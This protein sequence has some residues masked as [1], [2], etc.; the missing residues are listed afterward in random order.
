MGQ[1]PYG[2]IDQK[3]N[4]AYHKMETIYD[5]LDAL[6]QLPNTNVD[7]AIKAPVKI[8]TDNPATVLAGIQT[9]QSVLL[10]EG[11]R[12]YVDNST[13]SG[14]I[15]IV[16]SGSWTRADDW[17]DGNGYITKGTKF[18]IIAGDYINFYA[19]VLNDG[20]INIGSTV[21]NLKLKNY[22]LFHNIV[23]LGGDPLGE[24][25]DSTPFYK[26]GLLG[27]NVL[28]PEGTFNISGTTDLNG[29]KLLGDG[30]L[31]SVI[32]NAET[33]STYDYGLHLA[34]NSK[35]ENLTINSVSYGNSSISGRSNCAILLGAKLSSSDEICNFSE[36]KNLRVL[37]NNIGGNAGNSV[38]GF[39]NV[40]DILIENIYIVTDAA[41]GL[42]FHWGFNE[43]GNRTNHPRRLTL[44]NLHIISSNFDTNLLYF[45]GCHDISVQNSLLKDGNIGIVV[46]AGDVGGARDPQNESV[47]LICGNLNFKGMT[48]E[49][50][51]NDAFLIQGA[52]YVLGSIAYPTNPNKRWF[53]SESQNVGV[54]IDNCRVIREANSVNNIGI[55]IEHFRNIRATNFSVGRKSGF[56]DV[57]A[58]EALTLKA[59]NDCYVQMTSDCVVAL[60]ALSGKNNHFDINHT[61]SDIDNTLSQNGVTIRA[62][63]VEAEIVDAVDIN[64]DEIKIA[65]LTCDIHPGMLFEYN[66]NM[67]EFEGAARYSDSEPSHNENVLVAIKPATSSIPSGA[68]IEQYYCP[69]DLKITG[70]IKGMNKGIRIISTDARVP[71]NITIDTD[72]EKS[73]VSDIEVPLGIEIK[74][75][76]SYYFN[77]TGGTMTITNGIASQNTVI[78]YK[79]VG[80]NKIGFGIQ[81]PTIKKWSVGD[82][83][84]NTAN[85]DIK[86][87]RCIDSTGSGTWIE[88]FKSLRLEDFGDIENDASDAMVAAANSGKRVIID[89][90]DSRVYNLQG[91]FQL[92]SGTELV[93]QNNPTINIH[94]DGDLDNRNFYYYPHDDEDELINANISGNATIHITA[95]NAQND[96]STLTL[97]N[98]GRYVYGD[99]VD[100]KKV[101]HCHVKGNDFIIN[102]S[103]SSGAVPKIAFGWGWVEDCS[104]EGIETN[105]DIAFD[106]G[107]HWGQ[108]ITQEQ[109]DDAVLPSKTWHADNILFRNIK[110]GTGWAN[111]NSF[112][113][114]AAGRI[115]LENCLSVNA[116]E[117][118]NL[119]CGDLGY[120]YCENLTEKYLQLTLKNFKA[121][122]VKNYGISVDQ[123]TNPVGLF[124][125]SQL[126]TSADKGNGG[127]LFIDGLTIH[128][129]ENDPNIAG[130]AITGL[131]RVVAKNINVISNNITNNSYA[132]QL[133]GVNYAQF[134]GRTE[135][136][137]GILTRNCG[138][139]DLSKLEVIRTEEEPDSLNV[140]V[141]IATSEQ[142]GVLTV[143]A[144]ALGDEE[145]T[146]NGCTLVCGAGGYIKVT[147]SATEYEIPLLSSTYPTL[148]Q[149]TSS[150][151]GLNEQTIKIPPCPVAIPNGTSIILG[152]TVRDLR[153]RDTLIDKFSY[154]IRQS[155]TDAS[156]AKR[157]YCS[158]LAIYNAGVYGMDI[159]ACEDLK[160]ISGLHD[161]GG[162]RTT[163]DNKV[164]I[165]L[166]AGVESYFIDGVRFGKNC[167]KLRYLIETDPLSK[168]VIDNCDF[169][170]LNTSVSNAACIFREGTNTRIG[171]GNQY[172]VG[173]PQIYSTI[174]M[175]F[176]PVF[177]GSTIAGSPTGSFTAFYKL[178]NGIC[179]ITVRASFTNLGGMA[180]N[181]R[182]SGLPFNVFNNTNCR[183]GITV[184]FEAAK[185]TAT[186]IGGYFVE[187]SNRIDFYR[188]AGTTGAT[189]LAITDL[190]DTT[191]FYFS[192]FFFV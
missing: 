68:T 187:N 191:A 175:S 66:G 89:G 189:A 151:I 135:S 90:S 107:T 183:S 5:N 164:G 14:G 54:F 71:F 182:M 134:E 47:D 85:T 21:V 148:G 28:I 37:F 112:T 65:E 69:H 67:F 123:Q 51:V 11:D 158:N 84:Y 16:A 88:E 79:K 62:E 192:G 167:K 33:T 162:K 113:F 78:R 185:N 128:M 142:S 34:K 19:T 156:K 75:K 44:S 15:Y 136:Q 52:S 190:T 126:W 106:F 137:A 132:I 174:H 157:I 41:T 13:P 46:G 141:A 32:I 133:Y 87:W 155:S 76:G 94:M 118:L 81:A 31:E 100:A 99:G 82:Y 130:I 45:S 117:A 49:N 97:F 64:D 25:N 150:P 105:G 159:E 1:S 172:A 110:S 188:K 56:Q 161:Y 43:A 58:T 109:R 101:S 176:T 40:S 3:F 149:E 186:D 91:T 42:Q 7:L 92:R 9:I 153:L 166:G 138:T 144:T 168:G 93:F 111:S 53:A 38:A 96:G 154:G 104:V 70:K 160:I 55:T 163:T 20:N 72:F 73:V 36:L 147:I 27:S 129:N 108:N 131:D 184:G 74:Y 145:I 173:L 127:T 60:N 29:T 169:Q 86:G 116:P 115:T 83:I 22:T 8:Y 124:K 178:I 77:N 24:S 179:F 35:I 30:K 50:C 146:I 57:D 120:T 18:D 26:A 170:S 95:E 114:S 61:N 59:S 140:G 102:A 165:T 2:A 23:D 122:D 4:E 171:N 103:S 17:K 119:F 98:F 10:I 180:G 181:L 143:G 48:I 12:V 63:I 125:D 139:V 80:N 39:G 152:H 121:T 6:L 177:Y